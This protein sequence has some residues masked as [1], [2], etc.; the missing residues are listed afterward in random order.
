M[1]KTI[2][3]D[4]AV[5]HLVQEDFQLNPAEGGPFTLSQ[6]ALTNFGFDRLNQFRYW[7]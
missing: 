6:I 2:S 4:L 7:L 1:S 3:V 5:V